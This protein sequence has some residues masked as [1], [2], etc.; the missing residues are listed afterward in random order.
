MLARAASRLDGLFLCAVA[1]WVFWVSAA[2]RFWF[3]L[4]P[5]FQAVTLGA[6]GITA[7]LGLYCL[8]RPVLPFGALRTLLFAALTGLAIMSGVNQ[9]IPGYVMGAPGQGLDPSD[10]AGLADDGPAPGQ[11]RAVL[12]GREYVKI[13]AGELYDI[14]S[15]AEADKLG[16]DYVWRGFVRRSPELDARGECLVFRMA[17][18]CCFAD[19]TAVGFRVAYPPG[20]PPEDKAWVQ[21]RG[22]LRQALP[23]S[24]DELDIPGLA[25]AS[26]KPDYVFAADA[27]DPVDPPSSTF[28]YEW[29]QD[30]PYA[31]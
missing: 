4:N 24:Q 31:F 21:V 26:I 28:M 22:R 29:R 15:N 9:S 16:R 20:Q 13:N 25:L 8:W 3:Y 5:S 17:L 19:A 18:Y 10:R 11:S 7:A 27:V 30:E 1:A 12:A 14:A 2:G 23:V 6:A